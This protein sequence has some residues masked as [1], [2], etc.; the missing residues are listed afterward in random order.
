MCNSTFSRTSV[1]KSFWDRIIDLNKEKIEYKI[2]DP[3]LVKSFHNES[4]TKH[5]SYSPDSKD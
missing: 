4:Y 1:V 5:Q 2:Q 3:T